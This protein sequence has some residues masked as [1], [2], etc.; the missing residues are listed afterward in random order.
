MA[1]LD[2]ST[3]QR[4]AALAKLQL[5]DTEIDALQSDMTQI[6]K[7]IQQ[8]DEVA[9]DHTE[10]LAHA[11]DLKNRLREDEQH[12]SLPREAVLRNAPQQDGEYFVVPAVFEDQ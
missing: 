6:L 8:L 9:T 4:V 10:P 1:E 3:V 7:H 2:R 5:P 11:A 12:A